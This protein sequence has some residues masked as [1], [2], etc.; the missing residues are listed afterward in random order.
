MSDGHTNGDVRSSGSDGLSRNPLR[1]RVPASSA[2]LGPG[3]DVYGM[4]LTLWAEVEIAGPECADESASK[5]DHALGVEHP[6]M[7]A[8][9]AAGG[10]GDLGLRCAIPSGRG[11]GFSGAVRV[12]G[13][14]LGMAEA[15]GITAADLGAFIDAHRGDI[16]NQASALE[17][18]G[19]N[20]AASLYGGVTA[21]VPRGDALYDVVQ[22]PV[23]TRLIDGYSIAVWV[24]SFQTSTAKS[25]RS[26]SPTVSRQ[27]AVFN[28]AQ[29]VRLSVAFM[30]GDG[31][32][33]QAT[34]EDRLHQDQ[35]LT[36]TP[37]SRRALDT[38]M[39]AG[40]LTGWLSGSGPTVAALCTTTSLSAIEA[41]LAGDTELFGHGRALG[42]GIDTQGL[43]AAR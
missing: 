27:D 7:V 41:A 24:P 20:V 43:Q 40:A 11:L 39:R 17:G 36:D 4:A 26:L 21:A 33:L 34:R 16:M 18:H 30:T 38:M 28:V 37:L 15:A 13:V 14:S 23:S 19:D 6:A 25:R 29:A 10:R 32:G 2:N 42:L 3:F 5:G 31:H 9:R 1:V 12:A 8:F 35:R 22:V